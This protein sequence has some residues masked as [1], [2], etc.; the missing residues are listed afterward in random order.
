MGARNDHKSI[1]NS[2]IHPPKDF[3]TASDGDTL[4][5]NLNAELE[6]SSNPWKLS[7]L[8]L[9][10]INAAPPTEVDGDRYILIEV[11]SSVVDSGWDGAAINDIVEYSEDQDN[12]GNY[13]PSE[14]DTLYDKDANREYRFDGTDWVATTGAGSGGIYDGSGTVPTSVVATLTDD[15]TFS[16]GASAGV[17]K[18]ASDIK[19]NGSDIAH[20]DFVGDDASDNETIYA[21][22]RGHIDTNTANDELGEL[23]FLCQGGSG[24]LYQRMRITEDGSIIIG[25]TGTSDASVQIKD[26][27]GVVDIDLDPNGTSTFTNDLKIDGVITLTETTT[28][29][30]LT[31]YG[32]IYPKSDNLLYFQD[33]AGTEHSIDLDGSG[34]AAGLPTDYLTELKVN[35]VSATTIQIE[36]GSCRDSTDTDDIVLASNQNVA[37]TTSGANGLDT[38]SE[39]S[40]TWYYVYVIYDNADVLAE[41]GLLSTSSTSPTLPSGYDTFRRVGAVRNDGS[42]DFLKFYSSGS[43]RRKKIMYDED[44]STTQVLT[45]GGATSFTNVDCSSYI[46]STS[47][48]GYFQWGILPNNDTDYLDIRTDGGTGATPTHSFVRQG[49]DFAVDS[50]MRSQGTLHTNSTQVIEYLVS[51][52]IA[53]AFIVVRGYDDNL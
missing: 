52:A 46:P 17:V 49:G 38:G 30:A 29:S 28:P 43:G 32:K 26:S 20:L 34:G 45:A 10:D 12:W 24:T 21:Q 41:A 35:Y 5:R 33:G 9:A 15:I 36:A 22:I 51:D 2:Q 16:G 53:D 14:G 7:V 47:T 13:T 3:V 31:N 23:I 39:A 37:I 19:A 6:W 44:G 50:S 1:E 4:R 42:S 18:I 11:A 27:G 25:A 40:N 8:D 48:F